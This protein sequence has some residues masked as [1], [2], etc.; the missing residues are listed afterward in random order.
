VQVFGVVHIA[1][2]PSDLPRRQLATGGDPFGEAEWHVHLNP[3][4]CRHLIGTLMSA[5]LLE[6]VEP[7]GLDQRFQLPRSL[8]QD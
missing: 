5:G 6:E 4:Q 2:I 3:S 7:E 1:S 8:L